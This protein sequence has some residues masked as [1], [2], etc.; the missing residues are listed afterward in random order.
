V[1]DIGGGLCEEEAEVVAEEEEGV[2]PTY[3]RLDAEAFSCA[4]LVCSAGRLPVLA[5][6][7]S[8]CSEDRG[9]SDAA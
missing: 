6:S 7:R 1:S 4:R 9:S 3:R 8:A 2:S 5:A